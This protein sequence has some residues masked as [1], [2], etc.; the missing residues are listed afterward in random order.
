[1]THDDLT[2]ALR[3]RVRD[4]H[5]D[6][7]HLIRVSTRTGARLRRRRTV[8]V[9]LAGTAAAAVAVG[10]VA[11]S[12]GGSG[13]TAGTGPSV[14]TQPT[15]SA[16]ATTP[17]DVV[18]PT[19]SHE[20]QLRDQRLP[21]HVAPT[22]RGWGIGTAADDKF[23][24]T[25]GGYALSVNVRPKAELDAWSGG[26]PDRPASQV[27]HVGDNYF[28]TV[29]ASPGTPQAVIDELVDALRYQS[30]WRQ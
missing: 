23:P 22:L 6:V 12:L 29:Q 13:S 1:M 9:S 26:D 14:A 8:A 18:P 20:D 19:R 3:D 2:T 25:K 30:R 10:V 16:S 15:P 17:A 21:V 28:V 5:P 11:A 27:V 4:E 24:A 7:D